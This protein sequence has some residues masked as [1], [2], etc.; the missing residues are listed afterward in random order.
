M[1]AEDD[2]VSVDCSHHVEYKGITGQKRCVSTLTA[3]RQESHSIK[4][5][6]RDSLVKE[7]AP[8]TQ[9]V[10]HC[11]SRGYINKTLLLW[12]IQEGA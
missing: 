3:S 9:H 4:S 5:G 8:Y 12:L 6:D 2:V 1:Q 7:G 10:L 11:G